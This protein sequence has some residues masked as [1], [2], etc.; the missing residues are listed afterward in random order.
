MLGFAIGGK[1]ST[2]RKS[3]LAASAF[4]YCDWMKFLH[5]NTRTYIEEFMCIYGDTKGHL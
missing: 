1:F 2:H 3:Q 4:K 5:H